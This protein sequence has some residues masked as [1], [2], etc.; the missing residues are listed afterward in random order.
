MSYITERRRSS[1][2]PPQLLI[3]LLC[4]NIQAIIYEHTSQYIDSLPRFGLPRLAPAG[5]ARGKTLALA[6]PPLLLLSSFSAAG[7]GRRAKPVRC[8]RRRVLLYPL[9]RGPGRDMIGRWRCSSGFLELG[10]V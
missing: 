3:I 5:G 9:T 2:L 6:P 10:P 7:E 8:R 1:C 4:Q